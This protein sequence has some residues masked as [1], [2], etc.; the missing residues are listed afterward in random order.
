LPEDLAVRLY[1]LALAI[2]P[3]GER[4]TRFAPAVEVPPS[5]PTSTRLLAH[6]GRRQD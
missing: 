3:P 2:V 5:A 6:L 1:D 4:G